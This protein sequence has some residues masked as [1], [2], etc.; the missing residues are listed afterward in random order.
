MSFCHTLDHV[1]LRW[2]LLIYTDCVTSNQWAQMSGCQIGTMP[3]ATTTSHMSY[4]ARHG[5]HVTTVKQCSSE[6]RAPIQYEY[7]ILPV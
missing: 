1:I 2:E 6:V 7:D 4:M 5:Y 3:S